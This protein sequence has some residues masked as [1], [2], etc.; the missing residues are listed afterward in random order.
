VYERE[1]VYVC[2][3]FGVLC[4]QTERDVCVCGGGRQSE[5]VCT[6]AH[7]SGNYEHRETERESVCETERVKVSVCEK[8]RAKV[9]VCEKE[10]AKVGVCEKERAKVG[11]CACTSVYY[12][13]KER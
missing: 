1:C 11:V 6:C 8:E 7:T 12:E 5:R 10:R 13:H 4:A 3:Y 2:A 9:G